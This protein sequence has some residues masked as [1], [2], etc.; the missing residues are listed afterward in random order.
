MLEFSLTFQSI[1]D[2]TYQ[3]LWST[4]LETFNGGFRDNVASQ[5][6]ETTPRSATAG[7]ATTA[8]HAAEAIG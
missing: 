3:V 4:N 1:P 5:G 2:E 6:A 8:C 7:W